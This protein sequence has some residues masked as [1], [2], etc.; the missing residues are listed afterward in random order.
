M[1]EGHF[2][3]CNDVRGVESDFAVLWSQDQRVGRSLWLSPTLL[4]VD[5]LCWVSGM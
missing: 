5:Q 4:G 1:S 3:G 2:D